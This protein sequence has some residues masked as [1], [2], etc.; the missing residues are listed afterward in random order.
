MFKKTS[1]QLSLTEVANSISNALPGNDWCFIYRDKIYPLIDEE[2]FRHLYFENQGRP[3]ASIKTMVS[4]LIFMGLEQFN[5]RLAEF[6]FSRRIDW[7]IATYTDLDSAYIDHTTLFKFYQRLE[8]DDTVRELFVDLTKEFIEQC[9]VST[10]KQRTDSFFIHG[11]LQVLTRYGLFKETIRKFL[12]NL[13]KQK[14]GLYQNIQKELSKDYLEKE[15]DLTEKDRD[16]ANRKI[17]EMA[18]D[19]YRIVLAFENHHQ[20]K[21]YET[22]KILQKVFKQQC[23][24]KD[25]KFQNEQEVILKEK[26]D[27]EAINTPHNP[28]ATYRKKGKQEVRGDSG[29]VTETCDPENETQFITDYEVTKSTKH[30]SKEQPNIQ[31]RLIQ[32]DLKPEEQYGDAGFVNGETILKSKENG[33]ELEGPTAGRSQSFESYNSDKKPFDAGDF[34]TFYDEQTGELIVKKCPAGQ[35]PL[36]QAKS[37]KTGKI[38]VHFDSKK[39]EDC[40]KKERCPVH[41]GKKTATY[42][43]SEK[44]YVGAKRHHKYMENK[45]YRKKCAIRAGAEAIVSEL[46]RVHGMRKSRHYKRKRTNLQMGFAVISCNVKKFIK[47]WGKSDSMQPKM[48]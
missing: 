22:F 42:S 34:E 23:E 10:K 11:W 43:V 38:N 14:P 39:C 16:L 3:N 8:Q 5:W 28:E 24:L 37:T 12:M 33:I 1:P 7:M 46:T 20:I 41:I 48:V 2:K 21:H 45:E 17:S 40:D 9:G 47:T 15:F 36:N 18:K 29:F 25:G 4:I 6:H 31:E 44:E 32:N 27:K 30:D 19:L 26:P 35:I 13:R